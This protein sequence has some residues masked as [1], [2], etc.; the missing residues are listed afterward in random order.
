MTWTNIKDFKKPFLS[1]TGQKWHVRLWMG[2]LAGVFTEYIFYWDDDK[3]ET[4]KITLT[5]PDSLHVSRIK[6]KMIK[7]IN[8]E[9][10]RAK[11]N[12]ELKF[13]IERNLKK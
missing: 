9:K 1:K 7:L 12:C 4:G 2:D 6:Q 3:N 8:D 5:G 10:L 11:H 13:P